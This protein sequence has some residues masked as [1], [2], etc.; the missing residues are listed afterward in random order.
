MIRP[1]RMG[2]HPVS[3][4]IPKILEILFKNLIKI[5]LNRMHLI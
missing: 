4:F 5:P 1:K 3:Y 2:I